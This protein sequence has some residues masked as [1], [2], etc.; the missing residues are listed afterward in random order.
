MYC[1][2]IVITFIILEIAILLMPYSKKTCAFFANIF[3]DTILG[4]ILEEFAEED[5][6]L[7]LPEY[8][9]GTSIIFVIFSL[10]AAIAAVIWPIV[11]VPFVIGIIFLIKKPNNNLKTKNK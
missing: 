10:M 9:G 5:P 3:E 1:S 6:D 7:T 8:I 11:L 2:I 4:D